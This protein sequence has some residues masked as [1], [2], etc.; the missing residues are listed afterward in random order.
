M[1]GFDWDS[2]YTELDKKP[3][4]ACVLAV[5]NQNVLRESSPE[6]RYKAHADIWCINAGLREDIFVRARRFWCEA[7]KFDPTE[8]PLSVDAVARIYFRIRKRNAGE[9]AEMDAAMEG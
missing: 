8:F 9:V 5:F 1:A 2:R 4:V 6:K 7:T 3:L